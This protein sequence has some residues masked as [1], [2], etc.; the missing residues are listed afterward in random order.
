MNLMH[1]YQIEKVYIRYFIDH[2]HTIKGHTYYDYNERR[3]IS[4]TLL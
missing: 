2:L 4:L 3:T 1:P